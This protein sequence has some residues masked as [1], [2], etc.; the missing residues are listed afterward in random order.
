MPP[1]IV[2]VAK[3]HVAIFV[4]DLDASVAFYQKVFGIAPAKLRRGYAKF[5]LSNPPLNFTLNQAPQVAPGALSHLGIQVSTADDVL[6]TRERWKRNGLQPRDE[7]HTDCCYALQDKSW[8]RDPDGNEWEIFTVIEE[9]R[10]ERA[11]PQPQA[12]APVCCAPAGT[13]AR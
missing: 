3:A 2:R 4:K 11:A 8:V 9:D 7:M 1:K 13:A 6:A 10:A 5:D 12:G